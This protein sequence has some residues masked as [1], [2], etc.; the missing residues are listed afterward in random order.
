MSIEAQEITTNLIYIKFIS[1]YEYTLTRGQL[2][3]FYRDARQQLPQG[4][5]KPEIHALAL[6]LIRDDLQPHVAEGFNAAEL[7]IKF[8]DQTGEPLALAVSPYEPNW[9]DFFAAKK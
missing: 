7:W 8:D 3:Q 2:Q 5:A 1:G 4:T 6:Q 9:E